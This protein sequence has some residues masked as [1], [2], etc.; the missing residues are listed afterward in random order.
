[1]TNEDKIERA[2]IEFGNALFDIVGFNVKD[3]GKYSQEDVDVIKSKLRYSL[4]LL[5]AN[6][7][8]IQVIGIKEEL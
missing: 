4:G 7:G 5:S 2:L 8:S 6:R 1:M 3:D